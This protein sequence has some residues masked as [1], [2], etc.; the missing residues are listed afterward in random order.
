MKTQKQLSPS[1]AQT[2]NVVH[3]EERVSFAIDRWRASRWLD[4]LNDVRI[5]IGDS[6]AIDLLFQRLEDASWLARWKREDAILELCPSTLIDVLEAMV[7]F[8][9]SDVSCNSPG[10]LEEMTEC[11]TRLG[12]QET[13]RKN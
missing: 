9:Q 2:D 12:G 6:P 4:Q 7:Q 10:V 11:L 5:S 8:S 3:G 1:V 13:A